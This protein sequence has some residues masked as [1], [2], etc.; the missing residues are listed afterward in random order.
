MFRYL[1]NLY[2]ATD[3]FNKG[4]QKIEANGEVGE[5]FEKHF[6]VNPEQMKLAGYFEAMGSALLALSL[7]SKTFA[8][9][10]A[11]M[12]GSVTSVAA[13]KHLLAGDGFKGAQ[14]ALTIAGLSMV[15]LI[16]SFTKK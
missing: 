4:I 9:L 5:D 16:A 1:I 11:F 14:H 8:R 15:S 6:N 10:G 2:V 13:I 3:V 7:F 12:V